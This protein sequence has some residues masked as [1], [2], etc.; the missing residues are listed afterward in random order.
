[1]G[2]DM[3]SRTLLMS[4]WRF[5][6]HSYAVVCQAEAL[7]FA[8]RPG[9]RV[10]FE[11]LP[12]VDPAWRPTPALLGEHVERELRGLSPPPPDTRADA[13]LR[14]AY[15]MDFLQPPRAAR[16]VVFCTVEALE[17]SSGHVPA[18]YAAADAQR[19]HDLPVLTCS[20]WSREG[21]LRSGIREDRVLVVP[22][23][24]DPVIYRP[25]GA[26]ARLRQRAALGFRPEEFVFFHAGAMTPN[27]GLRFLFE[28]FARLLADYPDA[29]LLLKGT[30]ALY[31]S[32]TL[33]A[34]HLDHLAPADAQAVRERV[35]YVGD[36]LGAE[37]MAGLYH[38]ADCYVSSYIAE[39]F[40]L[41]VLE[42]AACGL[43]VICTAGGPTDDFVTDDFALRI[44]SLRGAIQSPGTTAAIGL[45][46]DG[47][48]LLHLMLCVIDDAEFR[49]QAREAGPAHTHRDYT[50]A[51]VVDRLMP[52]LLP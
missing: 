19:V 11:D 3:T 18:G 24:F 15:P 47:D 2:V 20:Q 28:A 14:F 45:I 6:P 36:A 23:G 44:E 30:D 33:L 49:A 41:P 46:P 42:A 16:T 52:V 26:E 32:A 4:G 35:R 10:C 27:K 25:A 8:R 1:M 21:L 29:R 39:G 34:R 38:A 50:W 37:A 51:R 9:V 22:L 43:P 17:L 7:E 40:N 5:I 13:E 31:D 12:Y 48:H